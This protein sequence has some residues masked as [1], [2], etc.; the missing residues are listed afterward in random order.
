MRHPR[1][2][3]MLVENLPVPADP[4][5]W[6]EALSLRDAGFS[7]SIIC[8]KGATK[9]QESTICIDGISIYRYTLPTTTSTCFSY[10]AEYGTAL[11]KTFG[12][13]LKVL[14]RS[15]FDAIHTA[16]PPDIFF[17]IGL[18]YRLLGKKFVFDQHDLAPE[19]FQVKF[20]RGA[21]LLYRLLLFLEKCSYRTAH[22][23]ITSNLSQKRFALERG[24]CSPDRAYVVRNGPDLKHIRLVTPE[25]DLKRGFPYLPVSYTHLTLPTIL[26]V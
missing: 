3:L 17:L 10:I 26:R 24:H 23:V 19:L 1:K 5:V 9:H 14:F 16:N 22:L 15:G 7:V 12:L 21:K 20:A 13:S 11:L 4:R 25:L 2:I 6:T 18:F 8:P